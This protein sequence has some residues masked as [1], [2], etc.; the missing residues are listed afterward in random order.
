VSVSRSLLILEFPKGYFAKAEAEDV[1]KASE[2]VL[3]AENP[4]EV[5]ESKLVKQQAQTSAPATQPE[6]SIK[7]IQ[8]GQTPEQVIAILGNPEVTINLSARTV[9]VYRHFKIVF[10]GGRLSEVQ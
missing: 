1:I 10:V 7:S 6:P 4:G 3:A 5:A 2:Q 9:Y 8:M